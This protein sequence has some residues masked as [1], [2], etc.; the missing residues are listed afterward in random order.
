MKS[1]DFKKIVETLDDAVLVTQVNPEREY[2]YEILYA[3]AAF[4]RLTGYPLAELVGKTPKLFQGVETD[5][6]ELAKIKKALD[7]QVPVHAE[8]INYDRQGNAYWVEMDITPLKNSEGEA[9]QFVSIEKDITALKQQGEP[10]QNKTDQ[11]ALTGLVNRRA[12]NFYLQQ[13]LDKY[14]KQRDKFSMVIFNIDQFEALKA[15]K[16]QAAS[17]QV[18][19]AIADTMKGLVRATDIAARYDDNEVCL[20]LNETTSEKALLL[21]ERLRET[22]ES[23]VVDYAQESLKV[24]LSLGVTEVFKEDARIEDVVERGC[25]ALSGALDN[26]GNEVAYR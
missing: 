24:T 22:V 9:T 20:I 8:V 21:A 10:K 26:G 14:R 7:A 17:D 5:Q 18:L 19:K 6:K 23:L 4:T 16:G 3:N 15:A 1:L 13:S 12:M 11:D 2:G 25:G